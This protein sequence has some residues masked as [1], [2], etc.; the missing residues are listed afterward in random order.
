MKTVVAVILV[1][2]LLVGNRSP[3]RYPV[4]SYEIR[5]HYG[6]IIASW[7]YC[8]ICQITPPFRVYRNAVND[9]SVTS[10]STNITT[11]SATCAMDVT[12]TPLVT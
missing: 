8:D 5:Q 10:S 7:L 3:V 11:N 12:G 9:Q 1:I 4:A 6:N 2:P